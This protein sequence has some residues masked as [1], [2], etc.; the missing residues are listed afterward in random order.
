MHALLWLWASLHLNANFIYF[1]IFFLL[2][3]LAYLYLNNFFHWFYLSVRARPCVVEL[4]VWWDRCVA[5][6]LYRKNVN[7]ANVMQICSHLYTSIYI[8]R[9]F[10]CLHFRYYCSR[11]AYQNANVKPCCNGSISVHLW[12]HKHFNHAIT[13]RLSI[14]HCRLM[15][16]KI[17]PCPVW[18]VYANSIE[19]FRR[20]L[21]VC[22]SSLFGGV[23][24]FF[25]PLALY[26]PV[27]VDQF[28]TIDISSILWLLQI[29]FFVKFFLWCCMHKML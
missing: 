19:R 24:C 17:I 20:A 3:P 18:C 13:I 29:L 10:G 12:I 25:L 7:S 4:L 1:R 22:F 6:W 16:C 27:C 28:R 8:H 14:V 11:S 26:F 2:L 9:T 21:K 15:P 23:I 5:G